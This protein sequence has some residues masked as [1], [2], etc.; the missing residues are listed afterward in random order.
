MGPSMFATRKESNDDDVQVQVQVQQGHP[1]QS[2]IV[3]HLKGPSIEAHTDAEGKKNIGKDGM[4]LI[5]V[6]IEGYAS[7]P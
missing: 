6:T 3:Y 2:V 4:Q 1:D 7:T 5:F